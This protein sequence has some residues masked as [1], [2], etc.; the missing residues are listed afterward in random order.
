[1]DAEIADR[2]GAAVLAGAQLHGDAVADLALVTPGPTLATMPDGSTP[3]V[4]GKL[5][6]P[7][8]F[9]GAHHA[10]E[11]AVDRDGVD[12]DEHLARARLRRR[13]LLELHHARRT[14]LA[15]HDGFQLFLPEL[16]TE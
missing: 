13:N 3:G 8:V 9:A 5:D 1:M 10:V 6:P 11:R 14:E 12:L 7:R 4:S 15:D 2:I 16:R